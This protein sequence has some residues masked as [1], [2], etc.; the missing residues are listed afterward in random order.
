MKYRHRNKGFTLIELMIVVMVISIIAEISIPGFFSARTNSRI[1]AC[2]SNLAEIDGA[3]T[4]YSMSFALQNG[5]EV[6]NAT[7]LV[8]TYL[9]YWPT[10]PTAGT[11]LANPVGEDPTYNGQDS[12]WYT[13]HCVTT[14]DS[15]C[16]F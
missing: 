3:K 15:A 10:G 11:Y 14:L 2:L 8:P 16:P 12:T 6:N 13:T 9:Q 5:A 4:H 7:A 1:Q